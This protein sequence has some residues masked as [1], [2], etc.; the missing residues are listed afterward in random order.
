M[1]SDE[2]FDHDRNYEDEE[3]EVVKDE[4]HERNKNMIVVC[5]CGKR[6]TLVVEQIHTGE[7]LWMCDCPL[8]QVNISW[9]K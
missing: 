8:G 4:M 1:S 9:I 5:G 2:V 3:D 6:M 7:G